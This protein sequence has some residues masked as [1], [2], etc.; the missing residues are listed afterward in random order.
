MSLGILQCIKKMYSIHKSL[1]EFNN[2]VQRVIKN[3]QS[4]KCKMLNRS[5]IE[6]SK[7]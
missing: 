6:E 2:S 3:T 7:K 1:P 4:I 5:S